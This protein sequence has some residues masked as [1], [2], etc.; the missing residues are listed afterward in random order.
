MWLYLIAS[1]LLFF[2]IIGGVFGGGIFTIVL[3]PLALV[4][5]GSAIL[6]GMWARSHEAK[7]AGSTDATPST[8]RPLPHQPARPSGRAPTSPE[9]LVDARREQQ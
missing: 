2:G 3:V 4:A 5:L 8:G 1:Q 7:A 9:R 6:A